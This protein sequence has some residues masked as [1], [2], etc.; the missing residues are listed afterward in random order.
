M[1][2]L[3]R[4]YGYYTE[5]IEEAYKID[6]TLGMCSD[7][8]TN[9]FKALRAPAED[10]EPKRVYYEEIVPLF[11]KTMTKRLKNNN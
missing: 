4:K 11:L 3:G 7:M 2:L 10:P 5:Q 9:Y 8:I 6:S 1:K